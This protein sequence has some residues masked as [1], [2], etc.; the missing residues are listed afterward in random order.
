MDKLNQ[1]GKIYDWETWLAGGQ[2]TLRKG[3]DFTC[4]FSSLVQQA[5]NAANRLGYKI[6]VT[7]VEETVQIV[8]TEETADA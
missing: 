7:E 8:V 1:F 4:S 6:Q 3:R 2:K 5:R